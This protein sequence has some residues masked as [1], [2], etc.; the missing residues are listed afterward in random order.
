MRMGPTILNLGST[1]ARLAWPIHPSRTSGKPPRY[2]SLYMITLSFKKAWMNPHQ[3]MVWDETLGFICFSLHTTLM[4]SIVK[5][6]RDEMGLT[7]CVWQLNMLL[8]Q[9][10]KSWSELTLLYMVS[11]VI[12]YDFM[13]V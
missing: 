2:H 7:K 5:E 11:H 8:W 3:L 12:A 10:S 6:H 4:L 13:M 9:S 1:Y